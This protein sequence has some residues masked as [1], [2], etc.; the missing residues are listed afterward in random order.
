MLK[1]T[2]FKMSI[3]FA[4]ALLVLTAFQTKAYAAETKDVTI[5]IQHT[6]TA[7][8]TYLEVILNTVKTATYD[9]DDG[10]YRGTLY[11][12]AVSDMNITPAYDY[13]GVHFCNYTFNI[14]YRGTVTHYDA[15]N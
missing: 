10:S 15:E 13:H 8:D 7:P 4:F 2:C 12:S 11:Y 5:A 3:C 9:Y 6:A 1:K 14:I